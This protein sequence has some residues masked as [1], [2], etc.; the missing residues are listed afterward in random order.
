MSLP[1]ITIDR[2][3]IFP[4]RMTDFSRRFW[5][6]LAV[7]TFETTRCEA[8]G[9][10]SFPPKPFCPHC[11]S[12]QIVWS[13]LSGQGRLYSQTVIHAAPAAFMAEVPY[14]VGIV[15][16]DENVRVATRILADEEPRLDGPVEIVGLKYL[17][18]PLFAA[19][20]VK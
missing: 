20:P 10:Y 4:P 13:L 8:C 1:I 12:K 18:G 9:L 3:R 15:D 16:L 6:S 2:V 11:W 19:R 17:D 14:R 7:G 5:R